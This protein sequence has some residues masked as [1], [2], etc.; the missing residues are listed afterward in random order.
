M[1]HNNLHASIVGLAGPPTNMVLLP[2]NNSDIIVNEVLQCSAESSPPPTFHQWFDS[3]RGVIEV[4]N[5]RI[6]VPEECAGIDQLC[7]T[8]LVLNVMRDDNYGQNEITQCYSV[9]GSQ[10]NNFTVYYSI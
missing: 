2:E 5:T 1:P 7:V 9:S 8:C 10:I 3:E 6:I 4:N